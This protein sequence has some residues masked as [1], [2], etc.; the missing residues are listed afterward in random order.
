MLAVHPQRADEARDREPVRLDPGWLDHPR[1]KTAIERR[2]PL[3]P[4]TVEALREALAER[5][6]PRNKAYDDQCFLTCFGRPWVRYEIDRDR[7]REIKPR[8]DDG[9]AKRFGKLLDRLG[10]RRPGIGLCCLRHTFETIAGGAK[11]QVA[12]A[13]IMGHVDPTMA[14]EY[15]EEI[16]D[17]RLVA[18]AEHVR[19]WLFGTGLDR[20]PAKA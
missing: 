11:D 7:E 1:P 8:F 3:W 18:V 2:I 12:V 15:R 17:G 9:V 5:P 19:P 6:E 14:A 13:S 10:L 20:N 4:E 16:A